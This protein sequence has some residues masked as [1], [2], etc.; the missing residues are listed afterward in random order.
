MS[1]CKMDF[2]ISSVDQVE[3]E[4]CTQEGGCNCLLPFDQTDWEVTTVSNLSFGQV[5]LARVLQLEVWMQFPL[6]HW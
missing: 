3:D 5:A 2:H 6:R 1:Q 4:N